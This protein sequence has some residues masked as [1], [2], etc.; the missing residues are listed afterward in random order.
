MTT[1][2]FLRTMVK[3]VKKQKEHDDFYELAEKYNFCTPWCHKIC[4][5][6]ESSQSCKNEE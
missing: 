5:D 3:V 2:E 6:C 4:E 1:V